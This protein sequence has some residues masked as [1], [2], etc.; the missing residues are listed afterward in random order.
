MKKITWKDIK[1]DYQLILL[2]LPALIFI[3]IFDYGPMYGLQIAFKDY[4][5]RAGIWGSEWVGFDHF[6]RFFESP[7]FWTVIKNT[8]GIS[9]YSLLASFPFPIMI[10]ILLNHAKNKY[11]QKSVQMVIYAPHFISVMVL[12][13]MIH[14][15][16]S[17]S[18]GIINNIMVQ[19]GFDRIHFLADAS[20][21]HDIFVWT[22]VWQNTGWESII[23][24]ASLAGINQDLYEAAK[25]DGANK[26]KTVWN[27]EIPQIL[28]TIVIMFIL[29]TGKF[30]NVGFQKAFL[31]QNSLN[32][33]HSEIIS[34]YVYKMG[35][36]GAQFDYATSIGLFN[37]VVNIILVLTVNSV[38]R[39][40][41]DTSLW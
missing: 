31:L 30:M 37:T 21:F 28:P 29:R 18:T 5:A 1:R 4:S 14:L 9:F 22:D 24:L 7:Y 26:W 34:T 15:F 13:G 35:L 10:A 12:C 16:L 2:C 17:P 40:L 11:F 39:R 33:S 19:F 36:L 3:F 27:V 38:C 25:I 8:L 6:K 41:N 23:Y 20:M 32:E